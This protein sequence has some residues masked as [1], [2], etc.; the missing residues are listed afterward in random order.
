MPK[1]DGM[2]SPLRRVLSRRI[3]AAPFINGDFNWESKRVQTA[4]RGEDSLSVLTGVPNSAFRTNSK[5]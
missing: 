4:I 3:D 1:M 2:R 5:V